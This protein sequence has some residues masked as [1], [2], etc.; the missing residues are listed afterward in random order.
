M[1]NAQAESVIAAAPADEQEAMRAALLEDTSPDPH[2]P[3]EDY[4]QNLPPEE[5]T[6]LLDE[7]HK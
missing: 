6:A 4:G 1:L 7:L 3:L 5:N 2:E